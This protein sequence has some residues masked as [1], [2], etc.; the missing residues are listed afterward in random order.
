[1]AMI[2]FVAALALAAQAAPGVDDQALAAVELCQQWVSTGDQDAVT[3]AAAA[4]GFT[5]GNPAFHWSRAAGTS[6]DEADIRVEMTPGDCSIDIMGEGLDRAGLAPA[7]AAWG[8]ARRPAYQR[9][10]SDQRPGSELLWL[11]DP[12]RDLVVIVYAPG[13]EIGGRAGFIVFWARETRA[14]R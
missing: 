3:A 11:Q 1:M 13:R 5:P 9:R 2:A 10:P 4:A 14:S 7:V 6:P 8:E 12:S